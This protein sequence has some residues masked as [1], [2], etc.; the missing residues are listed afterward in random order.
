[1]TTGSVP[2][3]SERRKL[4]PA[5]TGMRKSVEVVGGDGHVFLVA[6]GVGISGLAS[7]DV[8]GKIG[9]QLGG[10]AVDGSGGFDAGLRFQ[11]GGELIQA[12][13]ERRRWWRP[14]DR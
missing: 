12:L 1:M 5:I 6:A 14:A 8:E 2:W 3:V 9:R 7:E 10:Q 11:A 4:R 13:A